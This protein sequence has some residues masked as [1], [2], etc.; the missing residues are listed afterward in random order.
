MVR[1]NIDYSVEYQEHEYTLPSDKGFDASLYKLQWNKKDIICAL[2]KQNNTYIAQGIIFFSVYVVSNDDIRERIGV[3]ETRTGNKN[4]L[5]GVDGHIDL[6]KL[7]SILSF[8]RANLYIQEYYPLIKTSSIGSGVPMR[9]ITPI[10][11]FTGKKVYGMFNVQ[12]NSNCLFENIRHAMFE[13]GYD[14]TSD[15]MRSIVS[16]RVTPEIFEFYESMYNMYND[17]INAVSKNIAVLNDDYKSRKSEFNKTINKDAELEKNIVQKLLNNYNEQKTYLSKL[18]HLIEGF[19]FI[20]INNT[21]EKFKMYIKSNKYWGDECSIMILE[22]EFGIKI[23][24]FYPSS[25]T[26]GDIASVIQCDSVIPL[27]IR[28]KYN[29]TRNPVLYIIL[30]CKTPKHNTRNANNTHYQLITCENKRTFNINTLDNVIKKY[31]AE[32]C[33]EHPECIYGTLPDFVKYIDS[34]N[35]GNKTERV[36][37][38][39]QTLLNANLY[40]NETVFRFY[41]YSTDDDLPGTGS[42]EKIGAE[43]IEFYIK[44]SGCKDWRKKLSD[45]WIS[46]FILDGKRWN[47]VEHFYQASKFKNNN[48]SYYNKFALMP[49]DVKSKHSVS[50]RVNDSIGAS[51]GDNNS[52]DNETMKLSVDPYIATIAGGDAPNK[53]RENSIITDPDFYTNTIKCTDGTIKSRSRLTIE[54]AQ[55]AKFIQNPELKK[56]ILATH[57]ARLD[58]ITP[59]SLDTISVTLAIT[60]LYIQTH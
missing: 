45:M 36:E 28:N 8:S 46:E 2:G 5:T 53:Y 47:S 4:N 27:Y 41:D 31:I 17:I 13:K 51:I 58:K 32:K 23:I 1:S 50:D 20:K 7:G 52:I 9:E 56:I 26:N 18:K 19:E 24:L 42:F 12:N 33:I 48:P 40:N 59:G 15:Y 39:I 60:R 22:H 25:Y 37:T 16:D 29:R 30:N 14:I 43:G 54:R 35:Y 6:N 3:Y 49:N 44:L 55:L 10:I 21:F 38:S 34:I 11:K 57:R